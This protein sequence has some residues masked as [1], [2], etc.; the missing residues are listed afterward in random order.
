MSEPIKH[1]GGKLPM[2][3]IPPEALEGMAEALA[4]GA[5][6][7]GPR[8]WEKGLKMGRVY[9]ALM[10]H[11]WAWWRGEDRDPDS[12]VN[13]LHHAAACIAMLQAYWERGRIDLDDRYV[14]AAERSNDY[15]LGHHHAGARGMP[16][17]A[18]AAIVV[19]C[20]AIRHGRFEEGCTCK[21]DPT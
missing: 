15:I 9:G 12:G 3:L 16:M 8:N 14:A 19:K 18:A 11:L 5:K 7:Y 2:E 17:P 6:K 4:E 13:H 10:R 20:D 21:F 1:D